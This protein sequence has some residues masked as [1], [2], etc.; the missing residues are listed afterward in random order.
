[1]EISVARK[2]RSEE[3]FS[4]FSGA[5]WDYVTTNRQGETE[6][7]KARLVPVERRARDGEAG[8]RAKQDCAAKGPIC[9]TEGRLIEVQHRDVLHEKERINGQLGKIVYER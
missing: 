2:C 7:G 6:K 8:A 3:S 1:M 9:K 5:H 4:P